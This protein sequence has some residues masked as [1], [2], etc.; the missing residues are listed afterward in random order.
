MEDIS[1]VKVTRIINASIEQ[2]FDAWTDAEQ[3]KHWYSPEGMTTPEAVSDCKKGGEYAVT[4]KMGEMTFQMHGKYLEFERPTR[5]VFTWDSAMFGDNNPTTVTVDFKKIDSNKTEV[6]LTHS[7]FA[8]I[9]DRNQH[10]M[11][12][13]GTLNK[14]EKFVN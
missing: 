4:M 7:G 2:V 8:T 13:N 9:E 6:I 3:M 10:D 1:N 5:L 11:G 12:W 14:L